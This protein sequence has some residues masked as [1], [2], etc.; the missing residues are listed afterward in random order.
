MT[1]GSSA[2]NSVDT[3]NRKAVDVVGISM[4][5]LLLVMVAAV[6]V[7]LMDLCRHRGSQSGG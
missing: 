4:V 6:C 3:T 5:A 2:A 1:D 7:S